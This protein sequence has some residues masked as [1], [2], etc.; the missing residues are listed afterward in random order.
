MQHAPA[1]AARGDGQPGA[2]PLPVAQAGQ[3]FQ[4]KQADVLEDVIGIM[5]RQPVAQRN[6]VDEA[7]V[8]DKQR[9]PCPVLPVQACF[10]EFRVWKRGKR[11]WAH[12]ILHDQYTE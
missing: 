8:T 10:D 6:A 11:I 1:F 2:Q 9:F 5:L 4:Q 7:L 12:N 3:V